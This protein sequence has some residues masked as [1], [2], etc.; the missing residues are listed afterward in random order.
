MGCSDL[1]RGYRVETSENYRT[2]SCFE[3][4]VPEQNRFPQACVVESS[5]KGLGFWIEGVSVP[6]YFQVGF[7]FER[8]DDRRVV[9]VRDEV[10]AENSW[11]ARRGAGAVGRDDWFGTE[12]ER[13][14][15]RV[16]Q[17]TE[18]DGDEDT[19]LLTA[20]TSGF[21]DDQSYDE[22][23]TSTY[24]WGVQFDGG[25]EVTSRSVF[26][27]E[28]GSARCFI[29]ERE[30]GL[31]ILARGGGQTVAPRFNPRGIPPRVSVLYLCIIPILYSFMHACH[32]AYV[33]GDFGFS[34][35][36]YFVQLGSRHE[37]IFLFDLPRAQIRKT[38]NE[39]R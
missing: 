18:G 26:V 5:K 33:E 6:N 13:L 8:F 16:D 21:G 35:T 36:S 11:K 31:G 27:V 22:P 37:A 2:E 14:N 25:C 12:C 23:H 3:S 39:Q 34:V 4:T 15:G 38:Q 29:S 28:P 19:W 20:G 10:E 1:G 32:H 30:V 9:A 17:E 7:G 24:S